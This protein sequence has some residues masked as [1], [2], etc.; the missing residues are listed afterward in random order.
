MPANPD[1]PDSSLA[2]LTAAAVASDPELQTRVKRM[3][4]R[5]VSQVE[6]TL[7]YGTSGDKNALMKAVVPAMMKSLGAVEDDQ[8]ERA[9]QAAY[10][11]LMFGIVGDSK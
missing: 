3:V 5:I 8:G 7:N 9:K 2:S 10:D 1:R 11:R 6:F 4:N